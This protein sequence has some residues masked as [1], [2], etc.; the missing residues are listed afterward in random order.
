LIDTVEKNITCVNYAVQDINCEWQ[1]LSTLYKPIFWIWKTSNL[2]WF[3]CWVLSLCCIMCHGLL[4]ALL[5]KTAV[6]P[7]C[8]KLGISGC[9]SIW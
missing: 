8:L 6:V 2:G 4:I 7:L 5:F 1:T 9:I 3:L